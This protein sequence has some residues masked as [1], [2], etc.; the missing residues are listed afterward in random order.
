MGYHPIPA[1]SAISKRST[2]IITL[3]NYLN[4]LTCHGL[5]IIVTIMQQCVYGEEES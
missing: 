3:R 1:T 4:I 5:I 2:G